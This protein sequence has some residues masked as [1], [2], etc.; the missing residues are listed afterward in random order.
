MSQE[1]LDD[2]S[3][4]L[5]NVLASF[6]PGPAGLD[7]DRVMFLA[8]RASAAEAAGSQAAG[9]ADWKWP[10]ALAGMTA[11]A[12]TLAGM[13]VLRPDS[14]IADG[15]PADKS[16]IQS[17]DRDVEEPSGGVEIPQDKPRPMN[18]TPK[19]LSPIFEGM[20]GHAHLALGPENLWDL[21]A[22]YDRHIERIALGEL[23]GWESAVARS[24]KHGEGL[25]A[26]TSYGD[27]LILL[28][29]EQEFGKPVTEWKVFAHKPGAS[30]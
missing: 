3:A 19:P 26:S 23:D 27:W 21:K 12:A 10:A 2:A 14:Q 8:G 13:L 5:K 18:A 30:S 24:A 28:Q 1:E 7:R 6:R 15:T 25:P 29:R 17:A 11:L 16:P 4:A 22:Q 20:D 9:K